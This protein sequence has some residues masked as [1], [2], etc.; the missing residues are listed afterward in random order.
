MYQDDLADVGASFVL[1]CFLYFFHS[2]SERSSIA[3]WPCGFHAAMV[4]E[5]RPNLSVNNQGLAISF[6]SPV[7][8]GL[9]SCAGARVAIDEIRL[10]CPL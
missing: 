10:A 2:S 3:G 6:F 1:I 7:F 8:R 5:A 9:L 4:S